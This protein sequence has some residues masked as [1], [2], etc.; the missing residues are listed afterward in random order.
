MLTRPPTFSAVPYRHYARRARGE[1]DRAHAIW[2]ADRRSA[3]STA[4]LATSRVFEPVMSGAGDLDDLGRC[5]DHRRGGTHLASVNGSAVPWVNTV[6]TAIPAVLGTDAFGS[7][8]ATA[9]RRTASARRPAPARPP[10]PWTPADRR[11]PRSADL[12]TRHA[13][14]TMPA[15]SPDLEPDGGT[16]GRRTAVGYVAHGQPRVHSAN[17]A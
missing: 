8:L 5:R 15:R 6:G 16:G 10:P 7:R 1:P 11:S 13:C 4:S 2:P 3:A 17:P 9:D 14:F 12:G